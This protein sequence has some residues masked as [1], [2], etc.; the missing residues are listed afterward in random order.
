MFAQLLNDECEGAIRI[1]NPTSFCSGSGGYSNVD[2]TPSFYEHASCF[3]GPGNDV[4]FSFVPIATTATITVIGSS[5]PGNTMDAPEVALYQG[6][7]D[8]VIAEWRCETDQGNGIVEFT[9]GSLL[10]GEQYFIRVQ[11]RNNTTGTFELCLRNFNPPVEPG[12]DC[13]TMSILCNKESFVVQKVNG[14]GADPTEA[15]DATCFESVIGSGNVE[16]AS[17]WFSWTALNDGT[18]T[19][20]LIPI[21]P[22]DDLDFALY[23]L[24][25]GAGDCEGKILLRCMA[26]SCIGPT[27]LKDGEIDLGEPP[28][29]SDPRQNN[30]LMP[31]DMEAGKSYALMVNN[32]SETGNG[33]DVRFDGTGEFRGPEAAFATDTPNG[34]VCLDDEVT[35]FDVSNFPEGSI[36]DWSWDFG[37]SASVQF[38][39]GP[40]PH[41]ITY[42]R[43]GWKAIVL[44][45]TTDQ[46]CTVTEVGSILVECCG[47]PIVVDAGEDQNIALGK[48]AILS[49]RVS[50]PL[51]SLRWSPPETLSCIECP[52]PQASPLMP[53]TYTLQAITP[54][55][56]IALDSVT[57]AI[58][59][60]R[61]VF[62]PN[63][64]SPNGDGRNDFFGPY[65]GEGILQV[66][67]L[68]IFDRW[69][70]L[71]YQQEL[72]DL[73]VFQNGGGWDGRVEGRE[74]DTGVY[75][76]LAEVEFI[77]GQVFQY[78]GDVLLIR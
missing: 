37:S 74:A 36:V 17:T 54:D 42:D 43:P 15:N 20:D 34:T 18:L 49:G 3:S 8:D 71:L 22:T 6:A 68:R 59:G 25:N 72:A 52:N 70:N 19:F 45:V 55:G 65:G 77:D 57:V 60:D 44:T 47:D 35:I 78:A 32:F 1:D 27:G 30:Y 26:S 28:N 69:G 38:A 13:A 21:N 16:S 62:F 67:S 73:P 75:V 7:C 48:S 61:P 64:F 46:G 33:F 5:E 56:C 12:Q 39:E 4:W 9:R 53:T 41:T 76:Y 11:G 31:L 50:D 2:A 66:R 10:I 63:A 58:S 29:C 51:A 40:Q 14:P 23:E 24:P